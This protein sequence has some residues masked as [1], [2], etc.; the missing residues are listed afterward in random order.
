LPSSDD[1]TLK[2]VASLRASAEETATT[3]ARKAHG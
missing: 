1:V 2:V 3:K